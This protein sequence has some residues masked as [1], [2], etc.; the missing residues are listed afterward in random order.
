MSD[1]DFSIPSISFEKYLHKKL[2][3]VHQ[4]IS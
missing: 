1:E 3:N 2:Y 4:S